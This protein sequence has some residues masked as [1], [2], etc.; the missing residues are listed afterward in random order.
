MSYAEIQ[1]FFNLYRAQF[2]R[3][4][5]DAVAN[6]VHTPSAIT[7]RAS[8]ANHAALTAWTD[9]APMRTNMRALCDLYRAAGYHHAEFTFEHVQPMGEHHAFAVLAWCLKRADGS[10][11]QRFRTGYNVMRTPSG[12]KVVL[13]TQFEENIEEMKHDVA[14]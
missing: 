14:H 4:D 11:L 7:H 2:D 8:E 5:G 1:Q 6:L 12:P 13:V 9:D 10:V 3:L